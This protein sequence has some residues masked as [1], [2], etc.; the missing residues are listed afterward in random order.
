MKKLKSHFWYTQHQQNGILFLLGMISVVQLIYHFVDFGK[1]DKKIEIDQ[2]EMM[3]FQKQIDSMKRIKLEDE[4]PKLYP[5]NPNYI[6]DHKGY[7]LGMSVQE[8]DRLLEYRKKGLFVNSDKEFQQVTKVSDSLLNIISF[9]FKFPDWISHQKKE[10][11][12]KSHINLQKENTI[13]T[14]DI[15][16]AT[17]DDFKTVKGI[18][19]VL[20]KRIVNYR[21]KLQ[22]FSFSDQIFEVWGLETSLAEKVLEVFSIQ[23]TPKIKTIN[24]N[25]ATFKEVLALPY[26]NYD[27]CKK[28]FEY[29]DEVAELQ[30]I[31][32]LKKI[33]G[34]PLEK[35][36]R[37]VLYLSAK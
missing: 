36:D 33:K 8:I 2:S 6:T 9:Y 31:S 25:T 14:T 17:E 13:S 28:I 7:Q 18:G 11:V 21:A 32:E 3:A 30:S 16:L 35:Y 4:K 29:K 15:N 27:L 10:R 5:F 26:I 23:S 12:E 24:I 34:F 19:E 22:G 37:I 20:S 1:E